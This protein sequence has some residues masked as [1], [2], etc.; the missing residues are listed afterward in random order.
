MSGRRGSSAAASGS[1]ATY[2]ARFSPRPY[3]PGPGTL[4]DPA[5]PLP[6]ATR[7][8]VLAHKIDGMIQS[9][10]VRD[11]ADAARLAG[12]TRARM[13]QIANMLLL[14]PSIQERIL[15]LPLEVMNRDRMTEHYLRG[16]GAAPCWQEQSQI[17]LH[18]CGSTERNHNRIQHPYQEIRWPQPTQR[19]PQQTITP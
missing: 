2:H 8:L 10:E 6:S 16:V 15:T 5:A 12:V 1:T 18:E 7:L 11:W 17:L 4:G 14:S 13:T 19:F 9:G 3:A